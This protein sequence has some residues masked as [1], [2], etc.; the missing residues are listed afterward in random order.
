M[1]QICVSEIGSPG[2]IQWTMDTPSLTIDY[3]EEYSRKRISKM[4]IDRR[5]ASTTTKLQFQKS[6][7]DRLEDRQQHYSISICNY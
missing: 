6:A 2:D 3:Y 7:M 1:S 5:S 4:A